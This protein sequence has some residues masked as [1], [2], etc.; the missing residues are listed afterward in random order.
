MYA[1]SR[2]FHVL[3]LLTFLSI[4]ITSASQKLAD[5]AGVVKE[6]VAVDK[7]VPKHL[8]DA[9]LCVAVFP[10]MNKKANLMDHTG[11]FRTVL[12]EGEGAV[13][14]RSGKSFHE[15]WSSPYML[16]MTALGDDPEWGVKTDVIMLFLTTR[17]TDSL[18]TGSFDLA[19]LKALAGTLPVADGGSVPSSDIV[20]FALPWGQTNALA[21]RERPKY[22]RRNF[23]GVTLA[24]GSQIQSDAALSEKAYGKPTALGD[25]LSVPTNHPKTALETL[26]KLLESRSAAT[27]AKITIA[28]PLEPTKDPTVTIKGLA[29]GYR[30]LASI[31]VGGNAAKIT[32][33]PSGVEF[34]A[35]VPVEIGKTVISG[36][37][38][39]SSGVT[40]PFE[41]EVVRL[42]PEKAKPQPART[43]AKPAGKPKP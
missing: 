42:A 2:P 39:E 40:V 25:I 12:V 43:K 14:C 29:A 11:S 15:A 13:M 24:P 34:E 41:V 36:S 32:P 35:S 6:L 20:T 8:L 38:K 26:A 19:K 21:F 22:E 17:A 18:F 4:P 16:R 27:A 23:G 31:D 33:G 10:W 37:V 9:S 7:G 1:K 30:S 3:L 5:A 28:Q